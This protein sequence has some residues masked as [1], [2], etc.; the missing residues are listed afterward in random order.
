MSISS[1]DRAL[2]EFEVQLPFFIEECP[3]PPLFVTQMDLSR[4]R[5]PIFTTGVGTAI[6]PPGPG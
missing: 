6:S 1:P 3:F 5:R 4:F 2:A